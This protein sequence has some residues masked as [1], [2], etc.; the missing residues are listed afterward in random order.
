MMKW[1]YGGIGGTI[2]LLV[3]IFI[4]NLL[5][6]SR[7]PV[8]A[9]EG[10][11][12]K[13]TAAPVA[14]EPEPAPV[15][16]ATVQQPPSRPFRRPPRSPLPAGSRLRAPPAAGSRAPVAKAIVP[17]PAQRPPRRRRTE[18]GWVEPAVP[19]RTS[20][21]NLRSQP[22][23]PRGFPL[24]AWAK[25]AIPKQ[26]PGSRSSRS[27][28]S[29]T[30]R[31]PEERPSLALALRV[32]RQRHDRIDRRRP[33]ADSDFRLRGD[34]RAPPRRPGRRP[35]IRLEHPRHRHHQEPGRPVSGRGQDI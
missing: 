17:P 8:E 2:A 5:L 31:R 13:S 12:K 6:P 32:D 25:T 24:P 9:R 15:A 11:S 1:V 18:P 21:R 30:R 19:E 27:A 16:V 28:G 29:P 33:L 26:V 35:I 20:D 4:V 22:T 23:S 7:K 10:R 3:L 14:P 34:V